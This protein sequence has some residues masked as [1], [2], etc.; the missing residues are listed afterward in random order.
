MRFSSHVNNS[1]L[2]IFVLRALEFSPTKMCITIVLLSIEDRITSNPNTDIS[3]GAW[4]I[5]HSS[6]IFHIPLSLCSKCLDEIAFGAT[7]FIV[8]LLWGIPISC[9]S[10]SFTS[11]LAQMSLSFTYLLLCRLNHMCHYLFRLLTHKYQINFYT[12]M[13]QAQP[14]LSKFQFSQTYLWFYIMSN[15]R[16]IIKI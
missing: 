14:Y 10:R 13:L 7:L 11:F 12:A 1:N 4:L 6:Q 9:S 16:I 3:Q 15:F 8:R 5:L 2:S